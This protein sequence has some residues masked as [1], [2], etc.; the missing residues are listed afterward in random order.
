M[1]SKEQERVL[2]ILKFG[3]KDDFWVCRDRI[4]SLAEFCGLK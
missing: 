3:I 4:G 1:M 2:M